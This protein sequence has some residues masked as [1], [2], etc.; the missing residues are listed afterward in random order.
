MRKKTMIEAPAEKKLFPRQL[1]AKMAAGKE[2]E[3]MLEEDCKMSERFCKPESAAYV[4]WLNRKYNW[5]AAS[6]MD[7]SQFYQ[8]MTVT[9]FLP[10]FLS[11]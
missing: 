6:E 4:D 11:F 9:L 5:E 2:L 3:Q 1:V 7:L 8:K 10:F